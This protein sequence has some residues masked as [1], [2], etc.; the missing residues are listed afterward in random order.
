MNANQHGKTLHTAEIQTSAV[1][2]FVLVRLA[3]KTYYKPRLLLE[4]RLLPPPQG[5][6]TLVYDAE[7]YV[8]CQIQY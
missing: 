2:D 7:G 1:Q 6:F 3:L 5:E 4:S 8:D